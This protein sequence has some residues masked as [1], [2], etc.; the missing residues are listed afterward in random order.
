MH[1][2]T[3]RLENVREAWMLCDRLQIFHSDVVHATEHTRAWII[4]FD[5]KW[6]VQ[7]HSYMNDVARKHASRVGQIIP[8]F[9]RHIVK[10]EELTKVIQRGQEF[11]PLEFPLMI[12]VE[13]LMTS[14]TA[15]ST[16]LTDW[17]RLIFAAFHVGHG[18]AQEVLT[19]L[20]G[21]TARC[22]ELVQAAEDEF[23]HRRFPELK[24]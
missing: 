10:I 3:T 19:T 4:C 22:K 23:S 16:H 6:Q 9:A 5:P 24:P 20:T 8:F 12:P 14:L 21:R 17:H 15:L 7:N 2:H 1:H 18:H 13:P 11:E